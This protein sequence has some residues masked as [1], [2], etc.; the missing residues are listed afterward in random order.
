VKSLVD[1]LKTLGANEVILEEDMAKANTRDYLK[2]NYDERISLGLNCVGGNSALN[3]ARNLKKG[4]NLVTFG[5]M[6]REPTNFPASLFI[7]R[8][9]RCSGFCTAPT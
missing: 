7:F 6:S 3:L 8:E 9:L 2:K 4:G 5:A 1:E